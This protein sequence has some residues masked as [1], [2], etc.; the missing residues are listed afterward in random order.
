[1]T[2]QF[3]TEELVRLPDS[4]LCY[5]PGG[6]FPH[7]NPLP[8]LLNRFVTFGSFSNFAKVTKDVLGLWARILAAVPHSR[9]VFRARGMTDEHF[10]REILPI[11]EGHDVHGERITVLG[12]ARSVNDNLLDYH[13]IDIALDTFPYNGTTTTC[14][15]LY[16]G[17]PVV[18]LAGRSHVARVGVSLL[19][20]V[21]L[22]ELITDTPDEYVSTA[23][24]LAGDLRRMLDLRKS[25]RSRVSAS[26]LAD[27]VN[28]TRHLEAA[29]RMMWRRWCAGQIP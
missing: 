25:L 8:L 28:F 13:R 5:R 11:F 12:H 21:G 20:N 22:P 23:V 14:E 10:R 29:Y 9:L 1:M 26:P 27:N 4:F 6:D 19:R 7:E 3:H 16:M 24:A 15:S 17:V 2:E 18:T